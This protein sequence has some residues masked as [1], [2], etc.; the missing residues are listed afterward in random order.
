VITKFDGSRS[1]CT[2]GARKKSKNILDDPVKVA[3]EQFQ[4]AAEAGSD[5]GLRW[6]KSLENIEKSQ[7]QEA[8]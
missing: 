7:A 5:L 4:I 3:E 6:L 2:G 1:P 8:Q